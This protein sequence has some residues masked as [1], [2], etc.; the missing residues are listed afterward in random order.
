MLP[1]HP[2]WPSG[3]PVG[4]EEI[5]VV[6]STAAMAVGAPFDEA[7]VELYHDYAGDLLELVWVYVG[8]RAT[9][10]DIVHEAFLRV[11][12]A[13]GRLGDGGA[14]R[15]YLRVTAL[16]LA[17]SGFRRKLVALKHRPSAATPAPSPEVDVVLSENQQEVVTALRSLPAR[18]RQC[19]VLRYWGD[20]G[21]RDIA[22]ELGI[23]VNSVKTHM[24]RGLAAMEKR[25]GSRP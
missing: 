8:D 16:N 21:D 12:R 1:R 4:V 10:E 5:S 19:V 15:G 13:W 7:L 22:R 18:Q 3:R 14:G 6:D 23:S 17:R 20:L 24:R 25:L 9:A 11:H 2:K